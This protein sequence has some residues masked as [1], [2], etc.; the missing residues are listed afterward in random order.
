[1][2]LFC[3]ATAVQFHTNFALRNELLHFEKDL[4][5]AGGMWVLMLCGAADWSVDSRRKRRSEA[6]K[7]RAKPIL[8]ANH[9]Q[10]AGAIRK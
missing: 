3:L 8:R 7:P 10:N 2:G 9:E 4:A 5:I 6:D 1:M